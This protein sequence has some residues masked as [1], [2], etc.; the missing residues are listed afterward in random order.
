MRGYV[1]AAVGYAAGGDGAGVTYLRLGDAQAVLRVPFTFRPLP[2]L[3]GREIGYA[4]LTA[5]A[6]VLRGRGVDRVR[7]LLED[8]HLAADLLQRRDVPPALAMPYVRVRCAFN[9]F[10]EYH[11]AVDPARSGDLTARARCDVAMNLAA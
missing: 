11:V 1:E 2:A 7:L 5:V 10:K 6:P 9:R 4:A 3:L 8:E